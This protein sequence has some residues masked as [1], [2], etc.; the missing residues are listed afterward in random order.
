MEGENLCRGAE[1]IAPQEGDVATGAST[2]KDETLIDQHSTLDGPLPLHRPLTRSQT[3]R[4]PKRRHPDDIPPSEVRKKSSATRKKSKPPIESIAE[5]EDAPGEEYEETPPPEREAP[6][7]PVASAHIPPLSQ[8]TFMDGSSSSADTDKRG[9]RS[10]AILPIPVPNLTKKSRGRR[11]PTKLAADT[12][13]DKETRLYVCKVE[14]CGKCF[15]RGEHLKRHIRSIHTHEKPFKCDYASCGK[16]FNRHDNLLQHLKVHKIP[17]TF[18]SSQARETESPKQSPT[19][20]SPSLPPP[21]PKRKQSPPYSYSSTNEAYESSTNQSRMG[22]FHQPTFIKYHTQYPSTSERTSLATNMAV[23]SL[24]TEL[25]QSPPTSRK[26]D[27]GPVHQR[28][29]VGFAN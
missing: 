17:E 12:N 16:H 28:Y 1:E 10:R 29:P 26:Y 3:G 23:S 21:S 15:N 11:V 6:E 7:P 2:V 25:P 20:R 14:S 4:V 27:V 24:R 8:L 22:S 13:G 9:P 5:D 19:E 18:R